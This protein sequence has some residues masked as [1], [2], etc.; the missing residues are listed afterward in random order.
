M[1]A[2]ETLL[3]RGVDKIYPNRD[4]LEKVLRSEKKLKLYQG[5]DPTGTQ[6]H[7]G[8]AVALRK[9]RQ[10]QDLEHEVI[11]LIGDGTGQAGDPSGKKSTREKFLT[12]KELRANARDYINQAGKIVRFNG[13]NPVKILYN[14][15]WLNKLTLVDIL[16]IAGHFT[17]Q[18]LSERDLYQERIKSG[19][20]INLREFL[21]P[22]LQAYD[23][24]A[25]NVDLELGGTDQTFNMLAGRK[26]V[27]AM[28]HREK[29]VMTV[30]L[31][32][33]AKGTKIGKTEGNVIGLTDS[34]NEFYAKI[35]SLGDV[36]II[37]CFTL[38]TDTTLE[39]IESM[40]LKIAAGENPISLKKRLAFELTKQF[41]SDKD[42][43]NAQHQ[44]EAIHQTGDITWMSSSQSSLPTIS[45]D[46]ISNQGFASGASIATG[47]V[48]LFVPS[49][50]EFKR[51]QNQNA[52]EIIN[53][54]TKDKISV[55][56]NI[57]VE[58]KEGDIIKIGKRINLKVKK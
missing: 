35:M 50:S 52:I 1:D 55:K 11:F 20:D 29:F 31:L 51:L 44:F 9:L 5:F 25:M 22:L 58:I 28:Q 56:E 47:T 7:I 18:Q 33:D 49:K 24:V 53:A 10:F 21:Y 46:R 3:T 48:P 23:S 41:N 39:E 8:H 38:L 43:E 36:A 42:A 54:E 30:P 6:L 32:A 4:A 45:L 13:S 37:P 19:Q 40:K 57:K 15:D 34:P 16:N 14:S 27:A 12:N 17:W 26:L 2:I